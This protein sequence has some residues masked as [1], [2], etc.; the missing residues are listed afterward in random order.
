MTE[1]AAHRPRAAMR[2][3]LELVVEDAALERGGRRL[4]SDLSFRL[5]GGDAL[6]VTGRN[7][8]GKSTLLRALAGLLP[9]F[10]GS[11]TLS[12]APS[13]ERSENA[14]YLAH[15]D[16]LK[17]S[18]TLRE[19]LAFYADYLR[20]A[21]VFERALTPQ[22]ALDAVGLAHLSW[23]N[24]GI[25]SAGQ[26]RR[27]ALA[28]LLVAARPLWLLDEP[29]TALDKASRERIGALMRGHCAN[30]GIIIAATHEPLGLPE[31]RELSL[32][33]LA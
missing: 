29:M 1:G 33:A 16:G 19:N 13:D 12:G 2:P 15:A 21:A 24:A 3:A 27:A 5:A 8:V 10:A 22:E 6:V 4:I 23:A 25:L 28:R 7:G 31:A 11:A 30:G 32:E 14:H 26:K 9:F 17:L 18:L 20:A